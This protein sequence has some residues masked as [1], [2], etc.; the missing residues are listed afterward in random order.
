[1]QLFWVISFPFTLTFLFTAPSIE[2]VKLLWCRLNPNPPHSASNL[3][4]RNKID[5]I[6]KLTEQ[7]SNLVKYRNRFENMKN[8]KSAILAE[9]IQFY[10]ILTFAISQNFSL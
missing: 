10:N 9:A 4:D 3:L 6:Q 2:A 7:I 1:M 8:S 5:L